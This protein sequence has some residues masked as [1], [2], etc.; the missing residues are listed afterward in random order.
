MKIK[1]TTK[2]KKTKR[3][4]KKTKA[5]VIQKA[6]GKGPNINININQSQKGGKGELQRSQP[7]VISTSTPQFI[8]QP[9]P[10]FNQ[11]ALPPNPFETAVRNTQRPITNEPT[12]ELEKPKPKAP[13]PENEDVIEIYQPPSN[14]APSDPFQEAIRNTQRPSFE[15]PTVEEEPEE[16]QIEQDPEVGGLRGLFRR[17]RRSQES[18]LEEEEES[19]GDRIRAQ[20]RRQRKEKPKE[21]KIEQEP[22]EENVYE[23]LFETPIIMKQPEESGILTKIDEEREITPLEEQGREEAPTISKVL[24]V[25]PPIPPIPEKYRKAIE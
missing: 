12:N 20:F 24:R 3:T 19:E 6:K 10:M 15:R 22:E 13:E 18:E 25:P 9:I 14:L 7:S 11:P 21:I 4:T 1:K 5:R 2:T 17:F 16:V 23:R 8:P